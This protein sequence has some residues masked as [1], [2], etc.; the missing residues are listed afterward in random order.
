[1]LFEKNDEV[2]IKSL[3]ELQEAGL[4]E[5]IDR[6]GV[7]I[8]KNN[9]DNY[10]LYSNFPFFGEKTTVLGID[11]KD[12]SI[13]YW[14]SC[15]IWAPE[16]MLKYAVE[17]KKENPV[18]IVAEPAKPK[19]WINK[20]NGKPFGRLFVKLI[21]ID[22]KIAD[23]SSTGFSKLRKHELQYIARL[24][25]SKG[26]PD[27]DINTNVDELSSYCYNQTRLL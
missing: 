19:V 12:N 9:A 10:L 24:L 13:P 2:I 26:C 1:M 6:N 17:P 18:V 21:V 7:T 3:K 14:L 27:I 4:L 20:F 16:W 8:Y 5:T 11:E 22:E 15:G 25:M 23:F